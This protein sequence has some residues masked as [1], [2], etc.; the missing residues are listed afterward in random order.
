MKRTS[1]GFMKIKQFILLNAD[2]IQKEATNLHKLFLGSDTLRSEVISKYQDNHITILKEIANHLEV[3][4]VK[5]GTEIFKTLGEKF[6]KESVQDGLTLEETIDGTIF[7]KQALW[8]KIEEEGLLKELNTEDFYE[9]SQNIG[10]Y[11]DVLSSKLAF[12]YHNELQ[13]VEKNLRFLA[14]ASKILSSSLDLD[15]TLNTVASMVVPEIADWCG[16]DLLT[17][18]G[19]IRQVA[20]AHKDPKM[21]KW[22]KELRKKQPVDPNAPT[23][24]PNVLRNGKSEIYPVITDEMIVAAAKNKKQLELI[25]KLNFK[26]VMIVP[27][28]LKEK[29]VGAIS[30]V[31]TDT[32]RHYNQADLLMAEE[33]GLRASVALENASLYK[34]SQEAINTRDEF[35]SVASHELKTP[36]TSV[37]MFTQIL[38]KHSEQIGDVK[39]VEHLSR[40][41]KQINRLTELIYDLLN[42]S[43][44]QAGKMEFKQ[45]W[46]DFDKVVNEIIDV[47]SQS[48]EKHKLIVEGRTKKKICGDEERIGQVINNLISNAIKY[49]PQAN[50]VCIKLSSDEENVCVS[51]Q[52]FGIGM[53]KQH[54]EKI[55]ERFYRVYDTTDKTF[56]GLGIGLYISSE[57]VKR[58]GGRFW[59]KS[60]PGKGSTFSFSLPIKPIKLIKEQRNN[61]EG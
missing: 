28:F 32:D 27:I 24:V 39:A 38:I 35:I 18:D 42:I 13:Y 25:R 20:I 4:S 59:V 49:S 16:V 9:L 11:V 26:S 54:L 3:D 1:N 36:V 30:F 15:T 47:L 57:I 23:G 56:P 10:T 55:F 52:D 46:F 50:K 21:I 40:M 22:A 14:E 8:K 43:K 33:L 41:N 29:T 12:T 19:E 58:H 34:G 2:P 31:T 37:K 48:E 60:D 45:A 6:A 61:Y 53:A 5:K 17:T 44:I 7:L 51:V